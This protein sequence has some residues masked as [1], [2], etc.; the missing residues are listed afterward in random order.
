MSAAIERIQNIVIVTLGERMDIFNAP[1]LM[2]QLNQLVGNGATRFIVD[3]SAVRMVDAD[4]D[5]PLLHLL[6]RAQE[7]GGSVSLVCPQGNPI[8]VFYEMMR[9]DTLFE[10]TETLDAA[11][12]QIELTQEAV[13]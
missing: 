6:K 12:A 11:L 2:K 8:R 10:M 5:Y 13:V 1:A 4:G 7:V 3:L 9:L